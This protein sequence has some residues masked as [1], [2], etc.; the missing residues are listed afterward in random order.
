MVSCRCENRGVVRDQ[1]LSVFDIARKIRQPKVRVHQG[2]GTP[3]PTIPGVPL[4]VQQGRK[5]IH[6]RS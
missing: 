2:K 4:L 5:H 1:S 6:T 3:T